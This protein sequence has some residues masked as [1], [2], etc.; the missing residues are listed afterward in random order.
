MLGEKSATRVTPGALCRHR[1]FVVLSIAAGLIGNQTDAQPL[2]LLKAVTLEHINTRQNL[3]VVA[4]P[5]ATKVKAWLPISC[6]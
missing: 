6:S 3:C 5:A 1:L 4:L 2:Q